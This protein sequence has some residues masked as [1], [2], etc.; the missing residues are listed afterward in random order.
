MTKKPTNSASEKELDRA[1]DQFKEFEK[2]IK[3]LTVDNLSLAKFEDV[4]P[5]TKIA[6]SDKA[7]MTELYLKP[8]RQISSVEKFNE[9][10]R[11]K[12]N[13]DKEYV[14]FTAEN[15]EVIGEDITLW[16]KPY[17]GLPAQ[18]WIVPTNKPLWAP[19]YVAERIKGCKYHRLRMENKQIGSDHAG[20]YMGYLV[21]KTTIQRLDAFPETQR[22]SIFMGQSAFKAA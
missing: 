22:K 17:P 1:D 19:R 12:Y 13:Y 7:K 8:N 15:N 10:F 5:Q 21:A 16:T 6:E 20:Q 14:F 9:K 11:D 2:Q 3:D 18:E 4:E